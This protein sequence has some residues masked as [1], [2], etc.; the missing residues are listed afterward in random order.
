M[1]NKL[2]ALCVA[3]LA[4]PLSAHAQIA[5]N[6]SYAQ[7]LSNTSSM[8]QNSIGQT[9]T[10]QARTR[11]LGNATGTTPSNWCS[12]LPPA[13]LMR[14][15]DGHVPP[16]LQ[17]DPRYQDWLR[18]KG[19]QNTPQANMPAHPPNAPANATMQGSNYPT[20]VVAHHLPIT[21]TDFT[22]AVPGHPAI[23][24]YLQSQPFT[25]Q[26]KAVIRQAF[27]E[28]SSRVAK[29]ARPNNLAASVAVAVCG[30]IYLIDN[31]FTDADSDRYYATFNDRLG[32]SPAIATMSPLQKQNLSDG[33]IFQITV[34]ELLTELGQ[35]NPP[36][37]AQSIQFAHAMLLQLTGS[38][39][40]RLAN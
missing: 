1:L 26:Q 33:L 25:D 22:P 4:M 8:I 38:P 35:N 6:N 16:E 30:A 24:Q 12:P 40:G 36:V 29:T 2:L 19:G 9:I 31:K 34:A 7:M 23:E 10:S 18:C 13:D 27:D 20:P 39:T 15:V 37:K 3:S 11:S 5:P 21:A 14:G 17:S 32:A 28:M